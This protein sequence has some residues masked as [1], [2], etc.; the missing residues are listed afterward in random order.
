M[1]KLSDIFL[2]YLHDQE[3]VI[4]TSHEWLNQ[5]LTIRFSQHGPIVNPGYEYGILGRELNKIGDAVSQLFTITAFL[6]FFAFIA[7]ATGS[8]VVVFII[9]F[10]FLFFGIYH[11]FVIISPAYYIVTNQRIIVLSGIIS[12]TPKNIWPE[13]IR[14]VKLLKVSKDAGDI[15]F[16]CY[17]RF[18]DDSLEFRKYAT[19]GLKEIHNCNE[20]IAALLNLYKTGLEARKLKKAKIEETFKNIEQ[21]PSLI[22]VLRQLAK[23]E[24]LLW[25][26][27]KQSLLGYY[28][29]LIA[30]SLMTAIFWQYV[31]KFLLP[32]LMLYFD[33]EIEGFYS[34]IADNIYI[35]SVFVVAF[36]FFL[37]GEKPSTIYFIS[38][39]RA[40]MMRGSRIQ[41]EFNCHK[42]AFIKVEDLGAG[43]SN[44]F[45][46]RK[47]HSGRESSSYVYIGFADIKDGAYVASLLEYIG[48]SQ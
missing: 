12:L 22:K 29:K 27:K 6:A 28:A 1:D 38:N 23:D 40:V 9:I 2:P 39:K 5:R 47:V 7:Y 31:I 18:T 42:I 16:S 25:V 46:Q 44:V 35:F 45:F 33:I 21:N 19:V 41:Q 36:I 17:Y 26:E 48:I 15:C 20:A 43:I 30:I 11:A 13:D 32:F 3:E 24:R 8:W 37:F 14:K 34:V 10:I 4:W